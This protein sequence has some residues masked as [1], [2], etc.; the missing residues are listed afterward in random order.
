[1]LTALKDL[2][3]SGITADELNNA[4]PENVQQF[5]DKSEALTAI[6]CAAGMKGVKAVAT[7]VLPNLAQFR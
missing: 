7:R 2:L 3:G 1:M 6:F 5:L 4:T